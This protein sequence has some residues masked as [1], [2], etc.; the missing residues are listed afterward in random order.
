[1]NNDILKRINE[2]ARVDIFGVTTQKLPEYLDCSGLTMPEYLDCTKKLSEYLD[3][4]ER[5]R[6]RERERW[7][8]LITH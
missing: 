3:C 8:C 1:M 4:R 5:E 2:R 7:T 6:E